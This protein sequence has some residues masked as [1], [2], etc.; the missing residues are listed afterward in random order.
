MTETPIEY[1][2]RRLREGASDAE[3]RIEL[4]GQGLDAATVASTMTLAVPQRAVHLP[5]MLVG[6]AV[7][8]AG[9]VWFFAIARKLVDGAELTFKAPTAVCLIGA[10][11][12]ARGLAGS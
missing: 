2:R 10:A 3:V 5:T 4:F 12:F 11:I 7:I 9:L 1:A 8:S 6:L